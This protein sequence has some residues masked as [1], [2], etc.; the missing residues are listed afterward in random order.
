[1]RR[2][3][4]KVHYP[5]S[6]R[7]AWLLFTTSRSRNDLPDKKASEETK[8][9]ITSIK[10]LVAR[11]SNK[12]GEKKNKYSLTRKNYIF[13]TN[14]R[15]PCDDAANSSTSPNVS[16]L[17]KLF[18]TDRAIGALISQCYTTHLQYRNFFWMRKCQLHNELL[19]ISH[20]WFWHKR[21]V[22]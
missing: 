10:S 5:R 1:M 19:K 14:S 11:R 6:W 8:P 9:K 20:L 22:R 2:R 16:R 15:P 21:P 18:G 4:L 12:H 7:N 3:S 17:Q 13:R